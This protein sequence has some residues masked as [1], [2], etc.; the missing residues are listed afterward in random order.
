MRKG[1]ASLCV[2]GIAAT[3]AVYA[4]TSMDAPKAT[5]FNTLTS[6]DMEFMKFVAKYGK[7]YGTK[8]EYEFR[9]QQFK[10]A[11]STIQSENSK[12]GN[13]FTVG[14][15]KFADLTKAEYKKMLGYKKS[16]VRTAEVE[17]SNETYTFSDSVDW[18]TK[19]AVNKVKDQGQCGSCW[20]FSTVAAVEGHHAI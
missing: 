4:L 9:L 10:T 12:N 13:T 8:E 19:G 1:Y 5:S 2:V 20:A 11:Y 15:N 16:T 3:V 17:T 6:E 7:S 18:R 14:I